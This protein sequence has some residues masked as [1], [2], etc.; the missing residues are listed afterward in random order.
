MEYLWTLT[1]REAAPSRSAVVKHLR[2]FFEGIRE[3]LGRM[4]LVAVIE[5]GR[6]GTERLHVHFACNRWLPI[7]TI[8]SIWRHG[9]VWVGDPGKLKGRSS[10]RALAGYLSKY[11]AK[12][13]KAERDGLV[14]REPG[15]HRYLRTQGYKVPPL[16]TWMTSLPRALA[17][18]SRFYGVPDTLIAWGDPDNDP[19]H[20]VWL[21]WPDECLWRDGIPAGKVRQGS[22]GP[23]AHE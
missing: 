12:D 14:E 22:G 3:R 9:F 2:K 13:V 23:L 11:L 16:R 1:Y 18:L 8:R 10:A 21:Q 6:R 15:A 5:R 7:E 19:I 20:G 4:P 17:F